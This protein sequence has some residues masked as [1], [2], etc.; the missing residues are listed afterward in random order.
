[1]RLV[2]AFGSAP[3]GQKLQTFLPYPAIEWSDNLQSEAELQAELSAGR[4]ELLILDPTLRWSQ[5]ANELAHRYGVD[6]LLFYGDLRD[7]ANQIVRRIAPLLSAQDELLEPIRPNL[8]DEDEHRGPVRI[9]EKEKI[10]EVEKIIEKERIVERQIK[11]AVPVHSYVSMQSK[12]CMFLNLTPRAGATFVTT[13]LA[14]A[15]ANRSLHCTLVEHPGN[16][17]T[18]YDHLNVADLKPDYKPP[19]HV[20]EYGSL[21]KEAELLYEGIAMY[22]NHPQLPNGDV[23]AE[24]IM[25]L[26]YE[27]RHSPFIFYDASFTPDGFDADIFDEFDHVFLVVDPDPVLLQ[28]LMPPSDGAPPTEE[29]LLIRDLLHAEERGDLHVHVVV[30][31]FNAG[32]DQKLLLQCLPKKPLAHIPAQSMK[33]LYRAAWEARLIDV[34]DELDGALKPILELLVPD[35]FLRT[36]LEEERAAASGKGLFGRLFKK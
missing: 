29:F 3:L 10:V 36:T 24:E 15:I 1:M 28:R 22:L 19:F 30:N 12:V 34:D 27:L 21:K 13:T 6:V 5:E 14:T 18:L 32:V 7:T 16:R 26:V 20:L 31:K 11:V 33:H 2:F 4:C 8:P 23:S 9:I 35:N 17:P 25:K